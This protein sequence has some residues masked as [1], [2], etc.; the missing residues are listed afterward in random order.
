MLR[1]KRNEYPAYFKG[2]VDLVPDGDILEILEEQQHETLKFLYGLSEEVAYYRYAEDKWCIK[3]IIGHLVDT[4]RIFSYRA[5]CFARKEKIILPAFDQE[6]YV[7]NGNFCSRTLIDLGDEYQTVREATI[8]LF[9]NFEDNIY[10]LTGSASDFKIT[11]RS[12]PYILA[13]HELHHRKVIMERYIK[14]NF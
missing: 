14:R 10:Q 11:V 3:Q 13:G 7:N 1:P 9:R 2:Y 4:E 8:S 12:I 5:L 6:M